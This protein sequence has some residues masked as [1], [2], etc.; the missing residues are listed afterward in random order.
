MKIYA[1]IDSQNLNLAIKDSG[2]TLD[3]SR[4]FIYLKDKYK[5]SKTFLFIGYVAGNEALYTYLQKI[6]YVL[7]FKPTLEYKKEGERFTKGNVDAELVLHSM[8]EYPNYDK[9]IIVTGDGDFHCLIE[10]LEKQEKL[11]KLFIPNSR[12]FSALLRRFRRYF[13]FVSN[14]E[15]KLSKLKER[16]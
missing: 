8:I 16:E 11:L 6:G 2:W 14:L 15:N 12:K 3:F 5:V 9:A 13:I 7:V 10:Y 1:F 4:F